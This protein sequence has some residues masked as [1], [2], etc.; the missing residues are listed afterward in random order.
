MIEI[1]LGGKLAV[2]TGG[3][4]ELGRVICRRLAEAGADVAVH[5]H[6]GA[7]RVEQ[8]RGEIEAMGRRA[9]AVQADVG[10]RDSVFAMRDAIA[11]KLGRP[12]IIVNNAVIQCHPWHRV[13]D[14]D[15]ASYDSQYRSCVLHNVLMAKAFVPAMI[16]KGWG[17]V[18][19][20]NTEC[21][22]QMGPTQS[23]YTSGKR[24]Q[25]A[26]IRVL[27]REVG[28]H[29]ITVNQVAPGWM[30][31]D[32][33]RREGK[34]AAEYEQKLPLR[35]RG[36]DL[37]VANAVVFF[38]SEMARFITGCYLPVCGGHVMPCI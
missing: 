24:G 36:E 28:G 33:D 34:R 9:M 35:H 19:A 7:D 18:I 3:S 16:E 38:A 29:N 1:D 22:M 11:A 8:V 27:A 21:T 26:V 4:G 12:D 30:I 6:G 14:E 13:L 23:A 2:V 10:D 15:L 37:D 25:D 32:K 5:Y 20:T 17:R 31:S